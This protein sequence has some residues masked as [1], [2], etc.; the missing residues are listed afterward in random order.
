MGLNLG[1]DAVPVAFPDGLLRGEVMVSSGADR[2]GAISPGEI[3]LRGNEGLVMALA[4]DAVVPRSTLY[5]EGGTQS[6]A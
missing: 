1:E 5:C 3:T 6:D 4:P 2:D